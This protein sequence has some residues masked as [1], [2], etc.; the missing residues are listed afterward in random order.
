M[1]TKVIN[2]YSFNELSEDAKENAIN[3]LRESE[4]FDFY[5]DDAKNT[6]DTFCDIFSIDYRQFDYLEMYRSE[7]SFRLNDNILAMSGLRLAKYIHNNYYL[8]ITKPKYLGCI[9]NDKKY[10]HPC[11]KSKQLTN[12]SRLK[13]WFNPYYS[14]IT[15]E[16]DNCPLTGVCYDIDILNPIVQFL[17]KPTDIDFEQLL[18]DCLYSLAHSISSEYEYRY[19]DEGITE[20]IQLNEYL[21]TENGQPE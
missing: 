6:L 8:Q 15:R 17:K 20:T 2:L 5:L 12:K 1:K 16:M 21:F 3:H 11:I 7:Y 18:N 4:T 9:E 14:R 13:N 19:S 10:L